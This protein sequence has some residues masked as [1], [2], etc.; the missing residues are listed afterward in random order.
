ML[1]RKACGYDAA[2]I[3][4]ISVVTWKKTYEGLIDQSILDAREV[5][6]K[7]IS[8]WEQ[9]I[10]HP[11]DTIVYV[12]EENSKILGYLWGGIGRDER[13]SEKMEIYALY[14]LP[15]CQKKGI[16]SLLVQAFKAYVSQ[17]DFYA[18]VLSGNPS[19]RFYLKIGCRKDERFKMDGELIEYPFIFSFRG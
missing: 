6:S 17:E 13:F 4:E 18:F 16:G 1:I 14:V 11:N 12:A 10:L 7:R 2:S 19:E 3:A 9:R 5:T 15:D 8:Q